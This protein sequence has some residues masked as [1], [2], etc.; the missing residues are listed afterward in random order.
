MTTKRVTFNLSDDQVLFLQYQA[1]KE[2]LTV[3]DILRRAINTE[4]FL[5]E[6]WN[7]GNKVLIEERDGRFKQVTRV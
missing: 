1:S 6:Q 3:T 4:K 7:A 2:G 5:I